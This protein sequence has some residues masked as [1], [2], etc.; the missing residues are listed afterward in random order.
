MRTKGTFQGHSGLLQDNQDKRIQSGH[1]R[2][3]I[4]MGFLRRVGAREVVAL[5]K[6][7]YLVN[8]ENSF[9]NRPT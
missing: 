7:V 5:T 6:I 2:F 1:L 4:S 8:D 3:L 9:I